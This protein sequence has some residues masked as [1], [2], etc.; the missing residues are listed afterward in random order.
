MDWLD[1]ISAKKGAVGIEIITEGLAL[2]A[3]GC[4]G[5]KNDID[6]VHVIHCEQKQDKLAHELNHFVNKAKIHKR[7]CHLILSP[8]D[9]Q[10][11]LIEAPDV[12]DTDLREAARWRIKDLISTPLEKVVVDVFRLPDDASRSAKK[13]A[14]VVVTELDRVNEL[15]ALINGAGLTLASIDIAEMALRN[16]ALMV[17][18]QMHERGVGIVRIFQGGGIVLLYREGN[19][20]LSRQFQLNYNG[21]L[22]DDLPC[23]EL[24]LEIQRS[25]DYYERQMGLVPPGALYVG[26]ENISEDKICQDF[27]RNLTVPAQFLDITPTVEFV[28]DIDSA[29]TQ[30]CLGALGGVYRELAEP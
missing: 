9:Y 25:I 13:M 19:L 5:E 16:I 23:D 27:A 15:I 11:L 2:V 14:Y 24:A 1:K 17:N 29:M 30:L 8:A 3:K 7:L 10:L 26:G 28:D 18:D 22:L 12:D 6:L 20:Y 4:F 21:G